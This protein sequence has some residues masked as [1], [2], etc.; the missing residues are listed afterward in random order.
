M[1]SPVPS[2]IL[3]CSLPFAPSIGG[4]ETVSRIFAETFTKLGARVTV[5][6]QTEG[7]SVHQFEVVRCPGRAKLVE[8]GREADIILQNNI[9][10]PTLIPLLR[11]RKKIVITT[12]TWITRMDGSI[13]AQDRVKLLALRLVKNV[14]I[15]S[16][17]AKRLPVESKIIPNPVDVE[18]FE[19]FHMAHKSGDLVFMGRLVSDKGCDLLLKALASLKSKGNTPSL[20]IIGD[21]PERP[22]LERMTRELGIKGQVR[23]TGTLLEGRAEEVAKNKVLVVPSVWEEPFGLV[24]VEGIAAGCAVIASS[25]GGLPE[26]V[27]RCG[28]LFPNGDVERL[29]A[30]I[31]DLLCNQDLRSQVLAHRRSH[32]QT[33]AP[34]RVAGAYLDLFREMTSHKVPKDDMHQS[35]LVRGRTADD[36]DAVRSERL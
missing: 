13:G 35:R 32:L 16:A 5:V 8:L 33:F 34:K 24:A 27:G 14:A 1:T 10:L 22:K 11:F 4:I 21:G 9:S 23:F 2:H 30:C 26:A 29:A 3:I 17:I 28:L 7:D 19:S 6:T 31:R 20:T 25:K 12:H 18:R 36:A 15:S